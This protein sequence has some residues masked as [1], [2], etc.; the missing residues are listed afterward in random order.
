M[1]FKVSYIMDE[2]G[3]GEVV[4]AKDEKAA[5]A[6]VLE[7]IHKHYPVSVYNIISTQEVKEVGKKVK[8]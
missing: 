5:R 2:V 6:L 7:K 4:E 3:Y 8:E 1:K